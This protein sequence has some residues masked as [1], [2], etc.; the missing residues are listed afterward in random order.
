MLVKITGNQHLRLREK[1]LET[2]LNLTKV[3]ELDQIQEMAKLFDDC[4]YYVER[5]ANPKILFLDASIRLNQI[6]KTQKATGVM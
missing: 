4:Y 3:I 1:E 5:N 2:A 6:L